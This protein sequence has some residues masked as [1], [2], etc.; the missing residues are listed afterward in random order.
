MGFD[1][2]GI[3]SFTG[4]TKAEQFVE[5]LKNQEIRGTACKECGAKFFPPRSDCSKCLSDDM[6]WFTVSGEGTLVTFTKAMFAP[7]G[8]EKDVPYV[9]GVAEFADG[10]KV[11]G[12]LD[13]ALP[14]DGVKAGM[15]V[16][17]R[18]LDL[19]NERLSYELT[20]A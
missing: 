20:S 13:K 17:I 16:K 4:T 18:V 2:F 11:F 9:L 12:R 19:D 7:A 14:D 15:K 10:V 1:Q 8:F 5:F 6:E 3:I